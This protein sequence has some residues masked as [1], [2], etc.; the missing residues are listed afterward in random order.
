M[1]L[2]NGMAVTPADVVWLYVEGVLRHEGT[3][4]EK[5]LEYHP[6]RFLPAKLN[7]TF[8][9][10]GDSV[11]QFAHNDQLLNAIDT[12]DCAFGSGPRVCPGKNLALLESVVMVAYFSVHLDADLAC[13]PGE[14][15]RVLQNTAKVNKMPL[16]I[17]TRT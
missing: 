7:A 12:L 17:S 6:T 14:I 3:F 13:P 8:V 10:K 2:S 4:G 5:P 1:T 11:V 16:F 9:P 15:E